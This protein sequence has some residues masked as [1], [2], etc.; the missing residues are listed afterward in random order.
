MRLNNLGLLVLWTSLSLAHTGCGSG[1]SAGDDTVEGIAIDGSSYGA[2]V[3]AA[4]DVDSS[5]RSSRIYRYDFGSGKVTKVLLGESGNPAVFA[6][7][8]GVLIFNRQGDVDKSVRIYDARSEA[9]TPGIAK[10]L[11]GLADGDPLDVVPLVFGHTALLASGLGSK[12]QVLDQD[13]ATVSDVDTS[14]LA[15]AEFRPVGLLKS[16]DNVY[17]AH[18]GVAGLASGAGQGDGTQQL[19]VAKANGNDLAWTDKKLSTPAVDGLPLTASNPFGVVNRGTDSATIVGLCSDTITTCDAGADRLSS[20]SVTRL[21]A[22]DS[23]FTYTFLNR[24]VDGPDANTVYAHV[25]TSTDRYVVI[26]LNVQTKSAIVV[27]EFP[28]ERLY[29]LAYDVSSR[30]LF[31]GGVD[32]IKGSLTLYRDDKLIGSFQMD[33]MP[34]SSAFVGK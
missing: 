9:A 8:D 6:V 30:T 28:N 11:D 14:S 1:S 3:L 5:I 34:Y 18:S 33:G 25:H 27:H 4:V 29:G 24:I 17:I 31:V 13:Q 21:A 20:G 16:G 23:D 22:Y 26:K 32:G 10:T 19:F 2:M 15:T 7:G 12:L